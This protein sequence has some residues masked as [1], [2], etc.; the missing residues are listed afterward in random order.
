VP[1]SGV[2]AACGRDRL[3]EPKEV[4][5]IVFRLHATKPVEVL[6]VVGVLPVLEVRVDVVLVGEPRSIGLG[7]LVEVVRP[8][9]VRLGDVL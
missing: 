3:G 9:D 1:D 6:A 5:G 8:F 2:R 4:V 7:A